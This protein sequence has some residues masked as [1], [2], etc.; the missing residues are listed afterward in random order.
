M[1]VEPPLPKPGP[2]PVPV[3]VQVQVQVAGRTAAVARTAGPPA[4]PTGF[5]GDA[6]RGWTR[7]WPFRRSLPC[8]QFRGEAAWSRPFFS[9]SAFDSV[10]CRDEVGLRDVA[11]RDEF[12]AAPAQRLDEGPGPTILEDQDS[13]C[14]SRCDDRCRFRKVT[15]AQETR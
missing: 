6:R 15:L 14:R 13:C 2:V 12:G 11:G 3:Q 4:A 8:G 5:V 7:L 1:R 9:G 10:K